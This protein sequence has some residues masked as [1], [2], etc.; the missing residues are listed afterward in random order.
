MTSTPDTDIRLPSIFDAN[1]Q[2]VAV[3]NPNPS[4]LP[5]SGSTG[6]IPASVQIGSQQ[7]D[8]S[9]GTNP[10]GGLTEARTHLSPMAIFQMQRVKADM[11]MYSGDYD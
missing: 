8:N 1:S 9:Q 11:D 5:G 10:H 3:Q 6:A 4:Q 7:A 2:V